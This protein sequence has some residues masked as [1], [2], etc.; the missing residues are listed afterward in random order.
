MKT[1][2][3]QTIILIIKK[4]QIKYFQPTKQTTN[5]REDTNTKIRDLGNK[6]F[7]IKNLIENLKIKRDDLFYFGKYLEKEYSNVKNGIYLQTQKRRM[8]DALYCWYTENFYEELM[9]PNSTLLHQLNELS[10]NPN[11]INHIKNYIE[12]KKNF[13]IIEKEAMNHEIFDQN[14]IK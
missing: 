5:I 10:T 2:K 4:E 13:Q 14:E 1:Y 12:S 8:K 6:Y 7:E 9:E 3:K 11:F